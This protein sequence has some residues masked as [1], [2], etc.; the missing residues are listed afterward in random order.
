[1]G[2]VLDELSREGRRIDLVTS[3]GGVLDSLKENTGVRV[4]HYNYRFSQSRFGTA[5][6]YAW[7]QLYTFIFAFRYLFKRN[8]VF[9]IN[10]LLPA[11]PALA[12]RI[13][14]KR[15]VYHYH[16]NA[17]AK[18][19]IYKILAWTMQRLA[20]QIICVSEYQYRFLKRKN[21]GCVVP[22]A[23]PPSFCDAFEGAKGRNLPDD[24]IVLMPSSLK[25][26]KGP[27]EFV[28]LAR[29]LPH[30]RF[31]WVAN[32]SREH[33]DAFLAEM[34]AEMPEN[35]TVFERQKNLVP[36]YRQAALVVNLSDKTKFVETFG[37]TALEAMTAGLPVIVPTVGGIAELVENGV[38]GYRID[39]QDLDAI[40]RRIDRI[41]SDEELYRRLSFQARQ[42]ARQYSSRE[43][44]GKISRLL[45]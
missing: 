39:A 34:P 27:A 13:M 7:V 12:G 5:I 15:V 31:W 35:L 40:D 6:R 26:Y 10:T 28:E 44:A 33:I 30:Y 25:R 16:E 23:L 45:E 42:K 18:G 19:R 32:D 2:R 3:R 20:S 24:K 38:N 29:R 11:G 8:V 41:L 43:T 14:G 4:Y 37:L 17:F 22:N 21:K 1:M 36:F 9:Y